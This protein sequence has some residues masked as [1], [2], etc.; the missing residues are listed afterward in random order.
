VSLTAAKFVAVDAPTGAGKTHHCKEQLTHKTVMDHGI[1]APWVVIVFRVSL[2][3]YYYAQ[4]KDQG[5]VQYED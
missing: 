1:K 5:L 3:E 4:L 2:V